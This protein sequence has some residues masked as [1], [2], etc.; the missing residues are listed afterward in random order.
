MATE[1]EVPLE[2]GN[3][4]NVVR[5]GDTVRR[6]AGPW[7][8]FI[9]R[10]LGHLRNR[11]FTFAPQALG[12]DE[13][14]REILTYISGETLT[15]GPWP[16]W[17]RSDELLEEAVA[18]LVDYHHKVA[19]FRPGHVESRLGS[20]LLAS[21]QIVCHNDF[22]PY[23]CVYRDGH[24]AGL[25]DWDVVC[26][27]DPVWDLAFFAWH[28]VP[29]YPPSPDFAWRSLDICQRRL[30]QIVDSYGFEDREDFVQLIVARI[31]SSRDG[32]IS[33]ASEGDQA[34]MNLQREGHAEE[35]QR[36]IEFVRDNEKFLDGA[37]YV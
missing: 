32:I 26:A 6:E 27:G 18:V 9:H 17:V 22:A 7:T 35:M 2:G 8:P 5:V 14:G 12:I 21:D 34:F 16:Q 24:F 3:L 33:R 13:F 36:T 15:Y 29:L 19:D 23:N 30:K 20:E 31:E 25:I 10:L 11:G 28:W 1:K 37:L 4:T